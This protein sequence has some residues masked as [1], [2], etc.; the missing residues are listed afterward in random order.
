[1]IN[2]IVSIIAF[3]GGVFMS[4]GLMLDSVSNTLGK[5]INDDIHHNSK[6]ENNRKIKK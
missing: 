1:V 5:H 2:I 4:I 3:F 6:K